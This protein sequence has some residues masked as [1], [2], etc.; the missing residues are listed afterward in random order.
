MPSA[1][2]ANRRSRASKERAEKMAA[3]V[4]SQGAPPAKQGQPLV[5]VTTPYNAAIGLHS[6]S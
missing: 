2:S 6:C 5:E 1:Q 4:E 3:R